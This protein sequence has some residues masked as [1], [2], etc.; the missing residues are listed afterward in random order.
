MVFHLRFRRAV[1]QIGAAKL[2]ED[3]PRGKK[4]DGGT[5]KK[6][7]T[8]ISGLVHWRR[9]DAASWA[10]VRDFVR[11]WVPPG[12]WVLS[13]GAIS[14]SRYPSLD[15][16]DDGTRFHNYDRSRRRCWQTV[17]SIPCRLPRQRES[18]PC[19]GTYPRT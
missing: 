4:T 10:S 3:R 6:N 16:A 15:S 13:C 9:L 18:R 19:A 8:Q 7:G 14:H 17:G 2:R 11:E 1:G 12:S 5:K